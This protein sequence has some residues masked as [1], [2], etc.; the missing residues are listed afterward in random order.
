[1]E[2]KR[3]KLSWISA[4]PQQESQSSVTD[5][6]TGTPAKMDRQLPKKRRVIKHVLGILIVGL[7][8]GAGVYYY[9]FGDHSTKLRVDEERLT[10][11]TV[12]SG[13]FQEYIPVIGTVIPVKT[14]YL[15]AFE[16]GRV[17]AVHVEAGTIVK[18]GD[19]L[20]TLAN[21][22]LLLEVM[23]QEADLFQ[24]AN[25]LQN[26]RLVIEQ[27]RR[28][29]SSELLEL[30]HHIAQLKRTYE[31]EKQLKQQN[32]I[33]TQQFE[34]T[35]EEYEYLLKKR[36]TN[37]Q[38]HEQEMLLREQQIKQQE[39]SLKRMEANL[40]LVKQKLEN[41]VIKAPVTGQLTSLNADI[42]ASVG[43]GERLGQ[44]DVLDGF[45]ISMQVDEHYLPRINLEQWGEF[46][47]T[48]KLYYL[49]VSKIYPEVVNGRFEIEA[50]FDGEQPTEIRRGQTLQIRLELGNVATVTLLPRGGFFQQTGGQ[51]VY[52]LDSAGQSAVKRSLKLGRQN[53]EM[54]EVLEGLDPGEQVI[55]S[56]YENFGDDIDK[57]ILY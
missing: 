7:A 17:E 12:R 27:D 48:G 32:L 51:W 54:F 13:P 28:A 19:K 24:Q 42:G 18:K 30:D 55:T 49:S 25:D 57:L 20:L 37:V 53:P 39:A 21:T 2:S 14:V 44:I 29:F 56:S 33:P 23:K 9:F 52:V 43:R 26:T 46:S 4:H 38:N 22:D 40:L 3:K 35:Q 45:K 15:D 11:S 16:G 41:L 31:S 10:I 47:L 6:S 8:V 34:K 50:V 5:I 36:E 1:M